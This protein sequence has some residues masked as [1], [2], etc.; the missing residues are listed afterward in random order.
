MSSPPCYNPRAM[1]GYERVAT[2]LEERRLIPPKARV[3]IGVSGGPD[4]LCLLDSLHALGYRV[5]VAHLDH[6]LRRG[7][8]RDAEFVLQAAAR[9]GVPAVAERLG[10]DSLPARGLTLEE[11]ARLLRY[12]FLAGVARDHRTAFVA[13]G[14]TADD[15]AETILMHLLRGAGA[16]GLRGMRPQTPMDEI[17]GSE[18]GRGL[19]LVRPLL[20]LTRQDTETHCRVHG[21]RP[22]RDPTNQD[23]T[24]FRNRLRH[25]LLPEL[26]KY[27]PGI[28]QALT[29][30]GEV[31]QDEVAYLEAEVERRMPGVLFERTPGVWVF[32][33][34][35]LRVEP[36]AI[37]AE[38]LRTAAHQ[39]APEARDFGHEAVTR[40]LRWLEGGRTGK[41]LALPGRRELV[42]EGS[43]LVLQR[44]GARGGY[45]D[46]P[47][48]TGGRA[49][50]VRVPFRLGLEHGWSLRG[51]V[52]AAT[53][54]T[55]RLRDPNRVRFDAAGVGRE[56]EVGSV[57]PGERILLAAGGAAGKVADLFINRHI[58]RAARPLWPLVR[59]GAGLLWVA[60]IRRAALAPVRRSTRRVLELRLVPPQKEQER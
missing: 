20:G 13:V 12:R 24:Y 21:L 27:N 55:E 35:A 59:N 14:H 15:Q 56:L 25:R 22:R 50:R 49:R 3:V 46:W 23:S 30:L 1:P 26:T 16:H 32:R 43:V 9:Y 58:P 37:Q 7:S 5:V 18:G 19:V 48:L 42:D 4:S 36:R 29:R 2:F 6:H 10:Q 51:D 54:T 60:G 34:E 17:L 38:L 52:R 47:Q 33:K 8:W 39:A 45:P 31:M 53:A 28:R 41:R 57:H 11:G 40:C 44:L